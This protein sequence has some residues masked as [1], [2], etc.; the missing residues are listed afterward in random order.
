MLPVQIFATDISVPALEKARKGVYPKKVLNNLPSEIIKSHFT[1]RNG[2]AEVNKA[3]R[4]MILFSK[5]DITHNP[6]FLKLDLIVCRNL[7]I[8]FNARL[9]EYVFPVFYSALNTNGY[10]LLG[11]SESIGRFNDLFTTTRRDSKIFQ[12]KAGH[13]I[14]TIRYTPLKLKESYSQ[15]SVKDIS[16]SDMV[17]ETIYKLFQHPYVV[18]NDAQDIQEISGDISLYLGL[19]Q[20]Q[21]NANLISMA[22]KDLKIELRSLINRCI[23]E[24]KE[25]TSEHK[26]FVYNGKNHFVKI[27]V[28]PLLYSV[29]PN[30]FYLIIFEEIKAKDDDVHQVTRPPGK[31]D[32]GVIKELEVEL[33]AVKADLQEIIERYENSNAQ[34]QSLNEELQSANEELKIS[35]EELETANEELQ[36]SNEEINIA[37]GELR[38]ANENLERQ[39][40]ALKQSEVN[41]HALIS[42]TLQSFIL[43]DKHGRVVAFNEVAVKTMKNIFGTRILVHEN[44]NEIL[45]RNTFSKFTPDF[46]AAFTGKTI[47]AEYEIADLKGR[48]HFFVFSFT[49]VLDGYHKVESVSFSM[50]EITEL[51]KTKTELAKSEKLIDSVFHTADIGLALVDEKGKIIKVNNGFTRLLGYKKDELEGKPYLK[52]VE[53]DPR[54][55]IKSTAGKSNWNETTTRVHRVVTRE[56]N[57]L[58]VLITNNQFADEAGKTYFVKTMRDITDEKKYKELMTSAEKAMHIGSFEYNVITR[59]LEWTDEMY[60]IFDV[61]KDFIPD[62]KKITSLV[63]RKEIP[64][65][66]NPYKELMHNSKEV[67]VEFG[68]TTAQKKEKWVHTRILPVLLNKKLIGF[69]GTLQDITERKYSEME[70]ERLSWVAKHTNNAVVISDRQNKIEWINDGFERL[71]GYS[72]EEVT[73]KVA[74][75]LLHGIDT[76]KNDLKRV[77]GHLKKQNSVNETLKLYT[78]AGRALWLNVDVSPIFI[79]GELRY[80]IGIFTDLTELIKAKEIKRTQESLEQRQKLLNAMAGNFPEG[81]IGVI[82]RNLRYVFVGGSEL[83]KLGHR[84]NDWIGHELF[85][86]VS[87]EANQFASPFLKRVFDGESVNFDVE[88]NNNIYAVS[89]VPMPPEE[90]LITRALIVIQ[91]ITERKRAEDETLR[92]LMRQ[93]ELNELKSKFVS[94]ASHEF[95]TPLG[96]ILSSADLVNQYYQRGDNANT[97]KHIARIKSS[98]NNLTGILNEFLS[99]SKI[100]EGVMRNTPEE[101]GIKVCCENLVEELRGLKKPGQQI[102]YRHEGKTDMVML[103]RQHIRNVLINLLTNAIKYSSPDKNIYFT[104]LIEPG[105]VMFIVKDE[106]IGISDADKP[107]VFEAFFRAHNAAHLQGTGLGL[108]IVKRYLNLMKG[109]ISFESELDKGSTFTVS[110]PQPAIKG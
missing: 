69:R 27:V 9:Q 72:S 24:N 91:N 110:I 61:G 7:L 54:R 71:T 63:N 95:R 67:D 108:H 10:L 58:D 64:K 77:K 31:R 36:S 97:Q 74:I 6:P 105:L 62:F 53:R 15:K 102:L 92:A 107:Q 40:V 23:R 1:T 81:I 22:H 28:R 101:F 93:K 44:F 55:G 2:T 11:K 87:P 14:H 96:T 17:K 60:S 82:N 37:Y 50:L 3:I 65:I 89:A 70:I 79:E 47:Q 98:V 35:N 33:E 85:D 41:I 8:Y 78:N 43:L 86:K 25:V 59:K 34:L 80:F 88:A 42:N 104:S 103:D 45:S 18:I 30:E 90:N 21:M 75:D 66:K 5:H 29:N 100:E 68:I 38:T 20:G 49:P 4:S 26:K 12:R 99:L 32:Q 94:V 56:G 84:I 19:R 73:G 52:F 46:K 51:K 106:G 16:L 39:E 76:D 48:I 83:K 109:T 57:I 13:S